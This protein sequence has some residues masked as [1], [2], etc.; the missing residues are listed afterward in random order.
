[1]EKAWLPFSASLWFIYYSAARQFRMPFLCRSPFLYSFAIVLFSNSFLPLLHDCPNLGIQV[2]NRTS[3][4]CLGQSRRPFPPLA[5]AH[6]TPSKSHKL[7]HPTI[8]LLVLICCDELCLLRGYRQASFT[9]ICKTLLPAKL[10]RVP[11][12]VSTSF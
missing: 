11:D 6:F 9:S 5:P 8:S 4:C 12:A 10:Q 2:L 1:M 3:L 7:L